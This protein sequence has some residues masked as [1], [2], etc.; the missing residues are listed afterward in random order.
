MKMNKKGGGPSD[1]LVSVWSWIFWVFVILTFVLL[2]NLRS[3]VSGHEAGEQAIEGQIDEKVDLHD[4]IL[5]YLTTT[6]NYCD[7]ANYEVKKLT[8]AELITFFMKGNPKS[9]T[10]K[11]LDEDNYEKKFEKKQYAKYLKLWHECNKKYFGE[12]K[13]LKIVFW[14]SPKYSDS[15]KTQ[16]IING[17]TANLEL[18]FDKGYYLVN[19]QNQ[20]TQDEIQEAVDAG[21]AYHSSGTQ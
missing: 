11:Q 14:D 3:C 9:I 4:E 12:E 19:I 13:T 21:L 6:L 18:A 15:F 2:F 7:D 20:E 1:T 17:K 8:H 16:L 10:Q 5:T